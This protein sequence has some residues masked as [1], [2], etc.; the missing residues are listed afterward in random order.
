MKIEILLS[1]ISDDAV[2]EALIDFAT[3]KMESL[4]IVD[5]FDEPVGMQ[6][7][8]QCMMLASRHR[9]PKVDI[10]EESTRSW[11]LFLQGVEDTEEKENDNKDDRKAYLEEEKKL[12]VKRVD[13]FNAFMFAILG[14]YYLYFL[15]I[16]YTFNYKYLK[17]IKW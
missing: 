8:D 4:S 9:K 16:N 17:Y 7:V 5:V 15:I 2:Q 6:L 11:K 3:Q 13:A 12:F 10:D 14:L 1:L